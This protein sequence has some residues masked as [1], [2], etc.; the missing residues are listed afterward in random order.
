[1]FFYAL[2]EN[3][4]KRLFGEDNFTPIGQEGHPEVLWVSDIFV[5]GMMVSLQRESKVKNSYVC[6]KN[7][8][9]NLVLH[10]CCVVVF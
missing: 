2:T 8:L 10:D 4:P 7:A 9:K 3:V 5:R 6:E 1:M